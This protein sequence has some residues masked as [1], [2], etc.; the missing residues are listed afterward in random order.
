MSQAVPAARDDD[1]FRRRGDRVT[2]LEAFVDAS[3]AFSLTLLVIFFNQLPDSVDELR[4]ALRRVPTFIFCFVMLAMFWTAHNRWSRRFGLEDATSTVLSLALVLVVLI[5][6]YP[7]RM[8][9]SSFLALITGG[10]LHNELNFGPATRMLDLQTA[11]MIYSIGFGLLAGIM[12][13]LNAHALR[14]AQTLELDEEERFQT[15]SDL[16]SHAILVGSAAISLAISALVL[17]L[18]LDGW[19]WG[20]L[21]MWVYAT[22]G[23]VMPL[24]WTRREKR[25]PSH[26]VG[27]AG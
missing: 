15:R 6:V 13:W 24:Y 26:R 1:G 5:Y 17:L 14:Q 27:Q 12:W 8:V 18:G 25:R 7:L 4:D 10:W 20:G 2:R 23:A 9:I 22:L 16:G 19:L 11:F 3:F 21:P